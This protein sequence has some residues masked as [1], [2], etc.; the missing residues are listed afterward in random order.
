M[1]YSA[2]RC[3]HEEQNLVLS[4]LDKSQNEVARKFKYL[5]I[6]KVEKLVTQDMFL[7]GFGRIFHNLKEHTI[8]TYLL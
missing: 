6:N 2:V 8:T 4:A 1:C 5:V 3:D 7:F